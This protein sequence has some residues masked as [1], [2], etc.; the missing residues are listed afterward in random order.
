MM[1]QS[2]TQ[3]FLNL[4]KPDDKGESR[5]VSVSEFVRA[6]QALALGNGGSWCRVSSNLAKIYNI[7]FDKS[8]TKG[9]SIDRIKLS[10]FNTQKHFNQAIRK[11]IKEYYKNK[12]CVMLGINGTSE[13]T[14]IEID[15]KNGRKNE[16]RISDLKQQKIDDFQ[17]LS[18]AANDAKRQI[19]K[20]CKETNKRWNAK[21]ILGN[22]Y[23]FYKGNENYTDELG[24]VGCYQYDPVAYR[25]ECI[26]KITGEVTQN[27]M[28]KLYGENE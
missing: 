23:E 8:I 1:K 14:K 3:L 17:P 6:Y 25:K 13:N 21:N 7:E 24:C 16:E 10:G 28:Q 12:N 19:C 18:K 5:W 9:N 4:A 20:R 2:K 26:R 22:P 15:H 11:D 27:I